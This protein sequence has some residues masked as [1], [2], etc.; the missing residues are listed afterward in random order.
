[1]TTKKTTQVRKKVTKVN[2]KAT[3]NANLI[4]ITATQAKRLQTALA[5]NGKNYKF[6][7]TKLANL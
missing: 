1:M 5:R 3:K 2:P 7:D 4:T 6:L